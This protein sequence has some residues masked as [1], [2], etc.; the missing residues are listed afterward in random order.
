MDSLI[1]LGGFDDALKLLRA[2]GPAERI[3]GLVVVGEEA[4]EEFFEILFRPLHAMREP[5]L[6]ENT[7]EA[8]NEIQPGGMG[9]SVM[10]PNLRM[11]AHPA[12][13]GFILMNVQIIDHHM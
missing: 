11:T 13:G 7:E 2:F 8:F 3:A 5:L 4:V 1:L 10:K 9:R 6:G 12:A